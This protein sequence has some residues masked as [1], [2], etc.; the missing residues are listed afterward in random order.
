MIPRPRKDR[1]YVVVQGKKYIVPG[2]LGSHQIPLAKLLEDERGREYL[3]AIAAQS[4]EHLQEVRYVLKGLLAP[5]L[6]P[7]QL[8][9]RKIPDAA[10]LNL[11][12]F[13]GV[14]AFIHTPFLRACKS[15][16]KKARKLYR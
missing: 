2:Y 8:R 4:L 12:M 11:Y 5:G 15:F 7:L 14:G 9:P 1:P 6:H 13:Q 10:L 3:N 16:N